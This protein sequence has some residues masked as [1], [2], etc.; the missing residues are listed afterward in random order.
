LQIEIFPSHFELL[1]KSNFKE[2]ERLQR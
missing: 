1:P 2:E